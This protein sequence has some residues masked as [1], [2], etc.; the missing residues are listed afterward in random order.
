MAKEKTNERVVVYLKQSDLDLVQE[1][2]DLLG[3]PA[4]IFCRFAAL[5]H[6][7]KAIADERARGVAD[8]AVSK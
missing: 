1:A 2:A 8:S 7:R 5:Q 6:A 4:S 3:L